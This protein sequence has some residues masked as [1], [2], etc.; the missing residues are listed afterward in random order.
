M[1]LW[2]RHRHV[3]QF[4]AHTWHA[5]EPKHP[6][7]RNIVILGAKFVFE[8]KKVRLE[9]ELSNIVRWT[10]DEHSWSEGEEKRS[11]VSWFWEQ[12]T[13]HIYSCKFTLLS[14]YPS[15][16]VSTIVCFNDDPDEWSACYI[17]SLPFLSPFLLPNVIDY[18]LNLFRLVAL[19]Y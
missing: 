11:S 17:L 2:K 3:L 12:L 15:G 14:V 4:V 18:K 13:A 9:L 8:E 5:R 19:W 7:E 10:I 16:W 6:G 1:E